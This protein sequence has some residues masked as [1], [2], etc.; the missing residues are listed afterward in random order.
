MDHDQLANLQLR[1]VHGRIHIMG[2]ALNNEYNIR[3][4]KPDFKEGLIFAQ[5]FDDASEGFFKKILGAKVHEIIAKAFVETNNSY[6]HENAWMLEYEGRIV[7]MASGYTTAEKAGFNQRI[8]FQ[9][10]DD[11]RLRSGALAATGRFLSL[12]LGPKG[13]ADYYLQALAIS[14]EMRGKGMG[15]KMLEHS[16][17]IAREKGCK[18]LSLDVMGGN[19]R[20]IK[21]YVRFGMTSTS[22]FPNLPKITPV[23][24]RMEKLVDQA[25]P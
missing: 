14:P 13:K 1:P 25:T 18:T 8:L 11:A 24:S 12:F 20:A 7:G 21:S 19:K 23:F 10:A 15:Q 4:A 16:E 17:T 6:S 9:V 22:S 3:K 5:Y 2:G